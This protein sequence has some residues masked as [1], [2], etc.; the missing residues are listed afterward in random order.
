MMFIFKSWLR[1]M[2]IPQRDIG[3][4]WPS[5]QEGALATHTER[6]VHACRITA[7]GI[8]TRNQVLRA[9]IQ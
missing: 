6:V 5:V 7:Q 9:L 4:V 8:I 3:M 2:Q 1:R